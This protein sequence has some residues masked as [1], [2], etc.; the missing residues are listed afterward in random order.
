MSSVHMLRNGELTFLH[1]CTKRVY[2]SSIGINPQGILVILLSYSEATDL[3]TN[4]L[5]L[6]SIVWCCIPAMCLNL[7]MYS[8]LEPE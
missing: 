7:L 6:L 1:H 3:V 2:E 8:I 4:A 5:D